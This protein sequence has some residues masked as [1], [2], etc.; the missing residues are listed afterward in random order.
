VNRIREDYSGTM[1]LR[2]GE[3]SD[4][5]KLAAVVYLGLDKLHPCPTCDGDPVPN[6]GVRGG[7][8]SGGVSSGSCDANGTHAAFGATSWDCLPE[9]ASNVSGTGLLINLNS[10]PDTVSMNATLPCDTPAGGECPCRTCSGNGNLGCNSDAECAA[11]GFGT[12]TVG[13]GAGVRLNMCTG[14]ACSASGSCTTGPIDRYCDGNTMPDGRGFLPCSTNSDCST[15]TCSVL[16]LRRCFPDPIT[17]SGAPDPA[18]PTSGALFCI[19]P[20]SNPAINLA[21]GL[22]G[23]GKLELTFEADLRCKSDPNLVYEFPSGANCVGS[24]ATTTTTLLPLPE[25]GDATAPVCG[26]VCPVGQTCGANGAVCECTGL[27]LP[28]CADATSPVCGGVCADTNKI[29]MDNGGT[30]ACQIPTLPQCSGATSPTCGGVCPTGELC[31][32]VGGSCECG[33]PGAPPCGSALY[34]SC[35]GLCDVGSVCLPNT[36]GSSCGCVATPLPT[37]AQSTTPLCGGTCAVGSL[38]QAVGNACQC[39]TIPIPAPPGLPVP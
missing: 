7:T 27:P 21:A 31:T 4:R 3:W 15:G 18:V 24:E 35:A 11:G 36:S 39:T 38:C 2:T 29:C 6:D 8:C 22:P 32:D 20:T 28:T 26:G 12:C 33:A 25:C 19:A 37:C 17:A 23:P 9:T 5:L 1:N 30:C 16:D 14:F 13:G 10:T 34:P